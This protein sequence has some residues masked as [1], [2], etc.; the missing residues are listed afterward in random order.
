M[1]L[2]VDRRSDLGGAAGTHVF[3]C[4]VGDYGS[5][6]S[7]RSGP[8][9]GVDDLTP[10]PANA[11]SFQDWIT[12]RGDDLRVPL[13]TCRTLVSGDSSDLDTPTLPNLL[14]ALAEWRADAATHPDGMAICYLAGQAIQWRARE[15]VLLL[16]DF[17]DSLGSLLLNSVSV[18]SIV[19][20]MAPTTWHPDMASTQLFFVDVL[21]STDPMIEEK[22]LAVSQPTLAFDAPAEDVSLTRTAVTFRS[23]GRHESEY[24]SQ[25]V[26]AVLESLE[27]GAAER[28]HTGELVVTATGLARGLLER[29]EAQ[30][31]SRGRPAFE[32]VGSLNPVVL[33]RP[34]RLASVNVQVALPAERAQ[35]SM[36]LVRDGTFE[37]VYEDRISGAGESVKLDLE[38]GLYLFELSQPSEETVRIVESVDAYNADVDLRG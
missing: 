27:G 31:S 10:A 21:N 19:K 5:S 18:A 7:G 20:G 2:V 35:G 1:T 3:I 17:G 4:G 30:R 13:A 33:T 8:V 14:R 23:I 29:L 34:Q 32:V 26:A 38:P 22:V 25:F 16:S 37:T 9:L 36:L 15:T 6:R 11:L 12:A 24:D 28:L